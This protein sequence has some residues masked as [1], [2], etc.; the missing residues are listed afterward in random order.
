MRH[1]SLGFVIFILI[2]RCAIADDSSDGRASLDNVSPETRERIVHA[3]ERC[4]TILE[5]RRSHRGKNIIAP[6]PIEEAFQDEE[7]ICAMSEFASVLVEEIN[8]RIEERGM[9]TIKKC[10]KAPT[11]VEIDECLISA[12]TQIAEKVSK[13]CDE[14][15]INID[16]EQCKGLVF[17]LIDEKFTEVYKKNLEPQGKINYMVNTMSPWVV[18]FLALIALAGFLLYIADLLLK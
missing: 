17:T 4:V 18:K 9:D 3:Q 16:N 15:Y 14:M 8:Q 1:R 12:V 13:P 2:S 6:I 11:E 10:K 7:K 5:E